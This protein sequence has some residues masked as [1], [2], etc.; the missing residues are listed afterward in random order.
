MIKKYRLIFKKLNY[1]YQLL[2]IL[3]I[4]VSLLMAIISYIPV[5]AAR[6]MDQLSPSIFFFILFVLKLGLFIWNRYAVKNHTEVKSQALMMLFS[7]MVVLVLH[8]VIL[9]AMCYQIFERKDTPVMASQLELALAYGTY[10]TVKIAMSIRSLKKKKKI[11]YYYET[12]T[13][14]GWICALYTLTLFTDYILIVQGS[15]DYKWP[16]YLM[17]AVTGLVTL[18]DGLM[19][20][21][22]SS[23]K[24][25][26][27]SKK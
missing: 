1:K 20:I 9:T 5:F 3:G 26:K 18:F 10:A 6:N 2:E 11:N 25:K 8:S 27:L 21:I 23:N 17:I 13:Y 4:A 15:D 22:K 24:L 12:L 19:M 16:R 7:S 14:M